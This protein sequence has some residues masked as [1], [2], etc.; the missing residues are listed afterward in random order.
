[1]QING[2]LI[3]DVHLERRRRGGLMLNSNLM[4]MF[5]VSLMFYQDMFSV[6]LMFYQ[7]I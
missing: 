4:D 7:V 5:S 2:A 6:S 3:F 1:M